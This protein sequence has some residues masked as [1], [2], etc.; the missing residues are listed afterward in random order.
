MDPRGW[1]FIQ[2]YQGVR[3]RALTLALSRRE[4]G[5]IEVFELNA[6]TW[7]ISVELRS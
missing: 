4:R 3:E 5:L 2:G 6:S 1:G 7:G